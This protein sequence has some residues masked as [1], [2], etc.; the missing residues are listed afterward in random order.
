MPGPSRLE[1]AQQPSRVGGE[2]DG[3]GGAVEGGRE[4]WIEPQPLGG[5]TKVRGKATLS[6]LMGSRSGG[7]GGAKGYK[8]IMTLTYCSAVHTCFIQRTL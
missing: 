5:G 4:G 8:G 6:K 7:E 1:R 3:V 2:Q